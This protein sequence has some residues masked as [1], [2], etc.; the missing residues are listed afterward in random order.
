MNSSDTFSGMLSVDSA[1]FPNSGVVNLADTSA[2][3]SITIP[4]LG[5]V[6]Y[7]MADLA[8]FDVDLPQSAASKLSV[9][10]DLVSSGVLGKVIIF[11]KVGSAARKNFNQCSTEF[12]VCFNREAQPPV[13]SL[14]SMKVLKLSR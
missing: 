6:T 7:T 5:K 10:Q 1:L 2:K 11:G 13:Y 12:G 9:G 14:T 8:R 3:L 4:Q